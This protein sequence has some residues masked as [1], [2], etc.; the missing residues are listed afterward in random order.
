MGL[1]LGHDSHNIPRVP[2]H[3]FRGHTD[4]VWFVVFSNTGRYLA[5]ASKDNTV[6]VW[7]V[8]VR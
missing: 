3:V 6:I 2:V 5:S 8:E 1:A 4:E 7:D